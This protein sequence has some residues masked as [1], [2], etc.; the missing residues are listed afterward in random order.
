VLIQPWVRWQRSEWLLF[1]VALALAAVG[2]EPWTAAVWTLAP[3]SSPVSELRLTAPGWTGGYRA[4]VLLLALAGIVA[5]LSL[6][7]S[8]FDVRRL[9]LAVGALLA[10]CAVAA[11][12]SPLVDRRVDVPAS[13]PAVRV[14]P[15]AGW[16]VAT[17]LLASAALLAI[18]AGRKRSDSAADDTRASGVGPI[19]ARVMLASLLALVV[20]SLLP[21]FSAR[22]V[23]GRLDALTVRTASVNAWE[24]STPWTLG[25]CVTVFAVLLAT[26]HKDASSRANTAVFLL[27]GAVVLM[28]WPFYRMLVPSTDESTSMAETAVIAAPPGFPGLPMS[29]RR[30]DLRVNH[31]GE[32]R[33]GP[34]PAAFLGTALV[35]VQTGVALIIRRRSTTAV[36][37]PGS[38]EG[39]H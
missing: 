24:A 13:G 9:R 30:N 12:L 22:S 17:T 33:S 37:S 18:Q 29:V 10:G 3:G 26:S 25:V 27:A 39:E 5:L 7:G 35:V 15:L 1:A 8:R 20:V 21:W 36:A 38:I 28:C 23:S 11:A 14:M 19:T 32:S 16:F 31:L 4:G 2:A 34:E 6:K